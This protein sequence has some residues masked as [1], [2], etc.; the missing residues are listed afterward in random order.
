MKIRKNCSPGA[1][2]AREECRYA[3][4]FAYLDTKARRLVVTNGRILAS[5]PVEVEPG[6]VDGL[7]DLEP[8]NRARVK[9]VSL[10]CGAKFLTV[11]AGPAWPR[12]KTEK[13][14]PEWH[15]ALPRLKGKKTAQVSINVD[16]L[17]DLG[18]AAGYSGCATLRFEVDRDGKAVMEGIEVKMSDGSTRYGGDYLIM[19][20]ISD[21]KEP[22]A[23]VN[24]PVK[25]AK[26]LDRIRDAQRRKATK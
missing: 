13:G 17:S 26:K 14:Y 7:V 11:E 19:P 9:G 1:A 22:P 24:V 10:R 25:V 3:L 4:S 16:L 12:P 2:V 8:L 18:R 20:M 23:K 15:R 6:D 21:T 5:I